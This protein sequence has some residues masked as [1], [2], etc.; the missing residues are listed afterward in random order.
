MNALFVIHTPKDPQTAVFK[1]IS[2]QADAL[3]ARGHS[4]GVL[5]P[6]DFAIARWAGPRFNPLLLPVVVVFRLIGTRER[7][8]LIKFHSYSGWLFALL[9]SMFPNWRKTKVVTEFHGLEPIYIR[10]LRDEMGR[11]DRPL[12]WRYLLINSWFMDQILRTACRYSDRVLCLNTGEIQWMTE[13][14]WAGGCNIELFRNGA[15]PEFFELARDYDRQPATLLF[16]GQWDLR[17]GIHYLVN[18]F[19]ELAGQHPKLRLICAG[20]LRDAMTVLDDFPADIRSRVIVRSRVNREE[21]IE[22]HSMA[23]V[24]VFPTLF[25][26][27]SLALLEA[28]ASG[29]PIVTTQVGS[30][31]DIL[32]DEQSVLFV[33]TA[34]EKPL[35]A[36]IQR[37]LNDRE[38]RSSL[39]TNARSA[40]QDYRS[41]AALAHN[42]SQLEGLVRDDC[43]PQFVHEPASVAPVRN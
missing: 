39:G 34:E 33:P 35:T 38:M 11:C 22:L 41:A 15:A 25:E 12:S 6:E 13:N 23:D 32:S 14:E 36:A 4:V 31:P 21:L 42:V 9:R 27:S 24:F 1:V 3:R 37:L 7:L 5:A 28:M 2:E 8:D 30:A 19:T 40:A 43:C 16:V 26:G 20:T 10:A 17:K 29:M 18:S